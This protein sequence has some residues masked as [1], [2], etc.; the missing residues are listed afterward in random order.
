MTEMHLSASF[1]EADEALESLYIAIRDPYNRYS[2]K[3]ARERIEFIYHSADE[4]VRYKIVTDLTEMK[5]VSLVPFLVEVLRNDE[6]AM[7]RHEAA[8]GIG[9]LGRE[10]DSAPLI[11]SLENDSSKT[12]RHECAIALAEVGDIEAIPAL[13]G[14]SKDSDPNVASSA[15]FAIQ[16]ILLH[17][18]QRVKVANG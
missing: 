15:R 12:V 1:I 18:H 16:S 2:I 6:S 10:N 17:Y 3:E 11:E 13:E 7:I 5:S 9:A 14:A 4:V 8:F